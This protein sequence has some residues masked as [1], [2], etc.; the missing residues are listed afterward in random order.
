MAELFFDD[1]ADLSAVQARNVAVL[2]Y[3]SWGAAQA[4]SLRDS[5]VDVRIGLPDGSGSRSTAQADGLPVLTPYEA[6]EEADLVVV[7][8]P[9]PVQRSLYTEA[10]EPN[11]VDGDAL[12]FGHGFNLRFGYI[13]PPAGVDV[14]LVAPQGPGELVRQEFEDGRGVPV[15]VAVEQDA[16]ATAWDLALS[17]AKAIGGTRAVAIKTTLSEAVDAQL[18]AEQAVLSGGLSAL[19]RSG[20][21]TLVEAGH[22]PEV[23]Y[24]A[25]LH[26]LKETVDRLYQGG[27]AQQ[28][29][30]FSDTAEYGAQTAGPYLVDESVKDRMSDIL[31]AIQDGSWA[32]DFTADQAAGAPKLRDFR[33]QRHGQQI[34]QT[35]REL[36]K[37]ISWLG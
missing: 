8:A 14:I 4:L 29:G 36:S 22:Q 26:G 2:G 27:L 28:R 3:G 17:Y 5:G 7:L 16:S 18:F 21:E 35:G 19:V 9:D 23:A 13:K 25:C 15:L 11:L 33:Q 24:L 30:S 34:V 20:F 32:A 1:D 12:L 10:I 6:C 37:L 31:S